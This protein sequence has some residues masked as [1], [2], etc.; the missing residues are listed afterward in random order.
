MVT[1]GTKRASKVEEELKHGNSK[2]VVPAFYWTGGSWPDEDY[3]AKEV[4]PEG[5]ASIGFR[6]EAETITAAMSAMTE[7]CNEHQGDFVYF[8]LVL[9][10]E[11]DCRI[12]V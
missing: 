6:V 10:E 5:T 12:C 2:F 7:I 3:E 4:E 1:H 8:D 9:D 11:V